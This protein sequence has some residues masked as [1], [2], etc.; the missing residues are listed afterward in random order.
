MAGG[1]GLFFAALAA[2]ISSAGVAQEAEASAL[3]CL[4]PRHR[5]GPLAG[6]RDGWWAWEPCPC[7]DD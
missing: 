2:R 6:W 1:T 3:P 5:P 4:V 7:S